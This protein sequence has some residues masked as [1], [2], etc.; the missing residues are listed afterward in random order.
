MTQPSQEG[1]EGLNFDDFDTMGSPSHTVAHES[2]SLSSQALTLWAETARSGNL[3]RWAA[4]TIRARSVREARSSLTNSVDA[5][6]S[7]LATMPSSLD[8]HRPLT[9]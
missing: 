4:S 8:V 2:G 1:R 6:V 5:I 3:L 7:V 9:S